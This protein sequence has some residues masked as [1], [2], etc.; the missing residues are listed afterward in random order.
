MKMKIK[1]LFFLVILFELLWGAHAWFTWNLAGEENLIKLY[2]ATLV[3]FII[4]YVYKTKMKIKFRHNKGL[5]MAFLVYFI[6]SVL[7]RH[8]VLSLFAPFFILITVYPAIVLA[9]DTDHLDEL[10]MFISK[11]LACILL[12][13]II[14]Y[15]YFGLIGYP[16]SFLIEY[17]GNDVYIFYNYIFLI[18][19]VLYNSEGLKFQSVFLEPGYIGTLLAFMLYLNE[20]NLKKWYNK[21]M[22]LSLVISFSL[23]GYVT[24]II[25][26]GIYLK[27][28]KS[29]F[30]RYVCFI[31]LLLG[32]FLFFSNY[33]DGK[34][35]LNENIFNR[36]QVDSNKGIKGNNRSLGQLDFYFSK[37]ARSGDLLMGVSPDEIRIIN[38]NSTGRENGIAGAGYKIFFIQYGIMSTFFFFLFYYFLGCNNFR[39]LYNK[40]FFFLII[41]TFIQASYPNSYSWIVPYIICCRKTLNFS[42]NEY[43]IYSSRKCN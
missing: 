9:A 13:G 12:P 33:K 34:N 2:F 38:G 5:I 23:A 27:S 28:K 42:N 20:Y 39:S 7:M 18:R 19:G 17:P 3:L 26:Y 22:L 10:R 37:Y 36:L 43:S 31:A 25:G 6:A 21:I 11:A 41:I 29:D 1:L 4:S 15:V 8:F 35:Y 24:T 16:F 30:G 40:G 14:L 32:S